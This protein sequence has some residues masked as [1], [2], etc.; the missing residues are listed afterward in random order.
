MY[1]TEGFVIFI[2]TF[3]KGIL[4]GSINFSNL[5]GTVQCTC[6]RRAHIV[7]NSCWSNRLSRKVSMHPSH[8]GS[9]LEVIGFVRRVQALGITDSSLVSTGKDFFCFREKASWRRYQDVSLRVCA[10]GDRYM[11]LW[12]TCQKAGT[13]ANEGW[14]IGCWSRQREKNISWRSIVEAWSRTKGFEER[15]TGLKV[16]LSWCLRVRVLVCLRNIFSCYHTYYPAW[17]RKRKE[18]PLTQS[19]TPTSIQRQYICHETSLWTPG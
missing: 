8:R 7:R 13:L 10:H 18:T 19:T 11:S 17:S 16:G 12:C 1:K 3:C 6:Y 9:C 15:S 5:T 14:T 2:A 4:G